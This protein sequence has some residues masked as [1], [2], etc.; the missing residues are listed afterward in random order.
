MYLGYLLLGKEAIEHS[1]ELLEALLPSGV[2]E[3]R[4]ADYEVRIYAAVVA[5]DVKA[6]RC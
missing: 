3:R 6:T 5:S 2:T 4:V 1:E